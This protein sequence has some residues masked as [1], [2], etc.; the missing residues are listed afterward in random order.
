MIYDVYSAIYERDVYLAEVLLIDVESALKYY[1]D[2]A[3]DTKE[4]M[5]LALE[6]ARLYVLERQFVAAH[7]TVRD[8]YYMF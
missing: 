4:A 2:V 6:K 8:V 5:R 1:K 3:D 7:N